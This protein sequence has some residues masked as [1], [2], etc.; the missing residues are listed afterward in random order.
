MQKTHLFYIYK[1]CIY[2][3]SLSTVVTMGLRSSSD[4]YMLIPKEIIRHIKPYNR[5]NNYTVDVIA[6]EYTSFRGHFKSSVCSCRHHEFNILHMWHYG[7]I[8]D[9]YAELFITV[10]YRARVLIMYYARQNGGT[11]KADSVRF[12]GLLQNRSVIMSKLPHTCVVLCWR[13]QLTKYQIR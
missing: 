11:C 12:C 3:C 9:M 10:R 13:K 2:I 4:P 8:L 7:I 1:T 6:M 5:T